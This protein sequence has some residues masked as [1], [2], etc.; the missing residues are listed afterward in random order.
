[1][2]DYYS[3]WND[4]SIHYSVIKKIELAQIWFKLHLLLDYA[5]AKLLSM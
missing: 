2:I 1:M 5:E 3:V 4:Y